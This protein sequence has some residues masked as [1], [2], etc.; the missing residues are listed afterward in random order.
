[1]KVTISRENINTIKDITIKEHFEFQTNG[2]LFDILLDIKIEQA[3]EIILK[4]N[5]NEMRYIVEKNEID[6]ILIPN[7]NPNLKLRIIIDVP[8]YDVCINSGTIYNTK[9]RNDNGNNI[10]KIEL[11][12]LGG[13]V[14]VKE[15]T[16]Y[17]MRSIHCNK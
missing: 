15:F 2:K 4:F 10:D 6:E 7:V 11:I 16:I 3:K 14:Y 12:T 17:E 8:V 13:A 1:M 9:K 5:N